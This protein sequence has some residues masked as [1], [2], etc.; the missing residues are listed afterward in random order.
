[1]ALA[2]PGTGTNS[3]YAT[4]VITATRLMP[5]LPTGTMGRP[6]SM[7]VSSSARDPGS[8]TDMGMAATAAMA[9]AA[10]AIA[11]PTDIPVATG[12]AIA[13]VTVRDIAATVAAMARDTEVAMAG[14]RE[15]NM[16][17]RRIAAV[18]ASAAE[19]RATARDMEAASPRAV[20]QEASE[21]DMAA[22]LVEGKDGAAAMEEAEEDA[23]NAMAL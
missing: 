2:N 18:V 1:M 16:A 21:A 22:A 19:V 13:G 8:D 10:M 14:T 11:E 7:M 20:V 9:I 6:T 12:E 15:A 23:A 4:T 3:L 5:A 17:S